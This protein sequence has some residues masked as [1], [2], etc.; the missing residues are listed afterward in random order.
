M[1]SEHQQPKEYVTNSKDIEDIQR[2]LFDLV[3]NEDL[4]YRHDLFER[5]SD[6]IKRTLSRPHPAPAVNR[7]KDGNLTLTYDE[8]SLAEHDAAI[9]RKAREDVLAALSRNFKG[10]YVEDAVLE[11]RRFPESL[12]QHS[13]QAGEP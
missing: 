11:I 4:N 9:A 10:R 1:T 5:A 6:A 7:N 3:T 2:F 12:R 13:T 8:Y